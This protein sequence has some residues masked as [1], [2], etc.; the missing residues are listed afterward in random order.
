GLSLLDAKRRFL[1]SFIGVDIDEVLSLAAL[2]NIKA[3]KRA[4]PS[5]FARVPPPPY[6]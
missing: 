3:L 1:A 5:A 4:V 6:Q 2:A